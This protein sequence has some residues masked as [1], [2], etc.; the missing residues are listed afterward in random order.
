MRKRRYTE[1]FGC[2]L[3]VEE[4]AVMQAYLRER[5]LTPTQYLREHAIKP[6]IDA[7]RRR[8]LLRFRMRWIEQAAQRSDTQ[9]GGK[10][11]GYQMIRDGP[12]FIS[13][14]ARKDIRYFII[15]HTSRLPENRT[16][17]LQYCIVVIFR[18]YAA[19]ASTA[20]PRHCKGIM[21]GAG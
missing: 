8:Q 19:N 18:S 16:R 14:R 5:R 11:S 2:L 6:I 10:P 15:P 20:T 21:F 17:H 12:R 9:T 13:P 1:T 3:T 7:A 4:R